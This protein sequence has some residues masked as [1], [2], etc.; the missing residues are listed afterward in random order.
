VTEAPKQISDRVLAITLTGYFMPVYETRQPVLCGMPGTEDLFINV[1]STEDK[2]RSVM[3]D[4]AID[5]D[6]IQRIIDGQVFLE[7]VEENNA[8]GGRPYRLRVAVDPYKLPNGN[9]RFVEPFLEI[10]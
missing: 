8:A 4:L 7:S 1:F 10:N 5:F 2:L 3:A 6:R 9:I